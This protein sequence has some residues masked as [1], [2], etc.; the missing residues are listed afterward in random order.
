MERLPAVGQALAESLGVS[1]GELKKLGSDGKLTTDV[2]LNALDLLKDKEPPPP[3]AYKEFTAAVENLSIAFGEQLLPAFTPLVQLATS[4]L[5]VFNQLPGPLKTIVAAVGGLA[6]ALVILAPFVVPVT[7]GF[8][9]L[10]GLKIGATIAGWLPVLAGLAGTIK[11]IGL[12]IVGVLTGPVG[13]AILIGA[14][15]AAVYIFRDEIGAFFVAL[16]EQI[17]GF[18][19]TLYDIFVQPFVDTFNE[20]VALISDAWA[21]VSDLLLSPFSSFIELLRDEFITPLI[22]FLTGATDTLGGSW[23]ALGEILAAPFKA[24]LEFVDSNFVKPILSAISSAVNSLKQF[25]GNLTEGLKRPFQDAFNFINDN[26]AE[27][28]KGIIEAA[29]IFVID[30]WQAVQEGLTAPFTAA[31]EIIKGVLNSVI[32]SVEN[33]INSV[34]KS[35]NSLIRGVN[36]IAGAVGLPAIRTI[37]TVNLPRFA[38]G[39]VVNGPTMAIVGE[40]GQPEYIIPASKADGFA[41]NWMSGIRGPAAI[42]RFAE[43]G[44]VAPSNANVSI[45]T[46]PVTQMNGSN[47]VTTQD[48]SAAVQAG[49]KQTLDLI[50]R[51][52]NVRSSLGIA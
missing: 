4:A 13:I 33:T 52:G 16:G 10:A 44:M 26:F 11:A 41:A 37:K 39:G 30:S 50:R 42:P 35:V 15:L 36:S 19:G 47:Y 3:D 25:W 32:G 31:A 23:A 6:A 38:D 8:T 7:A 27:P 49:V 43:G 12:A 40:G 48:M 46:G 34:I 18:V 9:A 45:Q 51:D 20:V 24:T 14:V 21:S 17:A 2:V 22:D 1:V 5:N 29:T 28:V